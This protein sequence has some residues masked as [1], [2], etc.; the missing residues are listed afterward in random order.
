[1]APDAHDAG[2][3]FGDDVSRDADPVTD[4]GHAAALRRT[5]LV[6]ALLNAAYLVVELAVAASIGSVALAADAVD[7]FEDF[8]VNL[9][10]FLALGWPL[11][12]RAAVGKAMAGIILLPAVAALVL[13][14]VKMG[15]P[16]PPAAGALLWAAVGSLAV[17][18]ACVGLLSRFR[19]QGGSMT[20]AA[21]LAARNDLIAG[22]VLIGLAG[23]TALTASGWADII[24]GL[25]L[26]LLNAG[27]AKEVWEAATEERLAA[28]ALAGEFDDD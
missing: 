19:E 3:G 12:R 23:A 18:A 15:D 26:V 25:L 16:E 10:I 20:R 2:H 28:K 4:A 24:V 21:W 27:A 11:A 8:A 22:V 14:A 5:V 13:A 6:V 7:F 17:N 9:L 1:M